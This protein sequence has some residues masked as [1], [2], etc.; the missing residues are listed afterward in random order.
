MGVVFE[1]GGDPKSYI[2]EVTP[3][4]GEGGDQ[5]IRAISFQ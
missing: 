3:W 4:N 2:L 5:S 1:E